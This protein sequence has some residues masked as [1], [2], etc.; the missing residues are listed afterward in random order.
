M[1]DN[2]TYLTDYIQLPVYDPENKKNLRV[3]SGKIYQRI[4]PNEPENNPAYVIKKRLTLTS[5]DFYYHP[6]IPFNLKKSLCSCSEW[7]SWEFVQIPDEACTVSDGEMVKL[8]RIKYDTDIKQALVGDSKLCLIIKCNF[9]SKS[10]NNWNNWLQLENKD[11]DVEITTISPEKS[12]K[13]NK[14]LTSYTDTKMKLGQNEICLQENDKNKKE[15][16]TGAD[17]VDMS[18]DV[19]RRFSELERKH[20]QETNIKSSTGLIEN[21]SKPF[22][23]KE[24]M[25]YP[26]LNKIKVEQVDKCDN[27]SL[28]GDDR[29]TN[30]WVSS[31]STDEKNGIDYHRSMYLQTFYIYMRFNNV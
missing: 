22:A 26:L 20:Q 18:I 4:K 2:Q 29:T 14:E 8:I 9:E 5:E 27:N 24:N 19:L 16:V 6:T 21:R 7:L 1:I 3:I 12:R 10:D 15:N 28:S 30:S 17:S 23:K 13:G 31:Q 11:V 25:N